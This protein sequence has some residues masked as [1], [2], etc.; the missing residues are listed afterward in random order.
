[1]LSTVVS[2]AVILIAYVVAFH[3]GSYMERKRQKDNKKDK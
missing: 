2:V 1:M 3:L